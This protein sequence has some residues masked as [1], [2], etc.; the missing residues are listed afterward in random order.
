[1]AARLTGAAEAIRQKVG[2]PIPPTDADLLE[3]FLAP[4]RATIP[5]QA[6]HAE[7]AV[8]RTL[9]QQQAARLLV[10]P[11]PAHGTLQ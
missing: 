2:T 11:S 7:L 9:S 1:M 3:R 6:W 5:S 8:G 4:A 10:S